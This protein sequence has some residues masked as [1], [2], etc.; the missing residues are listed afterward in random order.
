MNGSRVKWPGAEDEKRSPFERF[1]E[2]ATRLFG[3][4]KREADE[5][6]DRYRTGR[7]G[8]KRAAKP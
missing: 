6:A 2:L 3:V 1:Q 5:K 8:R 7:L 4:P